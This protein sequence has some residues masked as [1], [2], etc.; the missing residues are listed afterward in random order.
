MVKIIQLGTLGSRTGLFAG[1]MKNRASS[2]W[3]QLQGTGAGQG[4]RGRIDFYEVPG[5]TLV[6]AEAYGL[7]TREVQPGQ[8]VAPGCM[9]RVFAMHIHEG[10]SCTGNEKDPY[11]NAGKHFNPAGCEHPYHAGDMPPLFGNG[12]YAWNAFF[13][14]RFRPSDVVGRTVILHAGLDDFTSQP[15]GNAGAKLACGEIKRS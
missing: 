15:A 13:T 14:D 1:L 3:A 6:T 4:I 2:A 7:P 10:G 8:T 12:G 11:A 9:G 5:G